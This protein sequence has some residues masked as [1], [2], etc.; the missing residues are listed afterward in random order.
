MELA[1]D[2]STGVASIALAQQG[3][4]LVEVTWRAEYNHTVQ[5]MPA[6]QA[7]LTQ[8]GVKPKD[9]EAIGVAI[10]PGSFSGLRVG[11]AAVKGLALA[12]GLP[13][14]G[15]GTLLV[16]AYPF[17]GAGLPVRPMLNAG[18]ED[19]ATALYE[20]VLGEPVEKALPALATIEDICAATTSVMLFCGEHLPVVRERIAQLTGG[21]ARFPP[22]SALFRRAGNLAE[23][24]WQRLSRG[25]AK[26]A[27]TI[28]P[29]YLRAPT[30]TPPKAA[31]ARQ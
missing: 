4:V 28:Q 30:I 6:I 22:Q 9:L 12:L 25:E 17:L 23:M 2:T 7:M 13:V 11:L 20:D 29:L 27:A 26:D 8:A 18:R 15:I 3:S 31:T 1:I 5:L 21:L 24:T 14:V 16:E 19:I 10:G